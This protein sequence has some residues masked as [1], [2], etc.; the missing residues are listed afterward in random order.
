MRYFATVSVMI[1]LGGAAQAE[2][3]CGWYEN[4]SASNHWLTDANDTWV[5]MQ[6]GSTAAPGFFELPQEAFDFGSGWIESRN[7]GYGSACACI[8]GD[9]GPVGSGEVIHVRSMQALPLARCA[10]DPALP[11]RLTSTRCGWYDNPTPA[12]HWLTDGD[13]QWILS[14]QG[15]QRASGFDDLPAE[16]FEFDDW[17]KTN[18]NYGYGCACIEGLFGSAASGDVLWVEAMTPL[19]LEKCSADPALPER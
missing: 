1:I 16:A 17:V 5:L 7:N 4:P 13:G 11:K 9:F 2:T 8:E 12:N 6:M 19:P 14:V 3:R 15:G 18:I 10:A